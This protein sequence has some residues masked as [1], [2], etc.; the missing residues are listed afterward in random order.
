MKKFD[1][2]FPDISEEDFREEKEMDDVLFTQLAN[3]S[4][5]RP[6]EVEFGILRSLVIF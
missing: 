5:E 4:V 6:G 2:R 3:A 1:F